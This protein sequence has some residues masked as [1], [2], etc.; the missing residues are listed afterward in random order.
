MKRSFLLSM[1]FIAGLAA[2]ATRLPPT[3]PQAFEL[4]LEAGVS[5]PVTAWRVDR[6]PRILWLVSDKGF[7]EGMRALAAQLQQLGFEVWQADLFAAEFLPTLPSS[8][9]KIPDTRLL[10]LLDQVLSQDQRPLVLMADGLGAQLVTRMAG[11]WRGHHRGQWSARIEKT[12]LV[13]PILYIATPA[14]GTE[15]RYIDS[16]GAVGGGVLVFQ[17]E[18]SPYYWWLQRTETALAGHGSV[19][20]VTVI[21]NVRDRF[22]FR[23]DSNAKEQETAGRFGKLIAAGLKE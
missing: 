18:L 19:V 17:P 8:V 10:E 20:S 3:Q 11:S 14:A 16:S 12:V 5:V 22:Y 13:S 6:G 1:V 15:A 23:P 2:C 9:G 4:G 7:P 21:K